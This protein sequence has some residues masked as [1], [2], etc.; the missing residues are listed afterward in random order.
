MR[1]VA[2]IGGVVV[3]SIAWGGERTIPGQIAGGV[4]MVVGLYPLSKSTWM[5]SNH[6]SA[7]RYWL[8]GVVFIVIGVL[9]GMVQDWYLAR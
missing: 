5:A 4:A 8:S 1:W 2:A 3:A 9:L 7:K 6:V